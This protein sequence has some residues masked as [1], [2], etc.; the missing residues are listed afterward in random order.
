VEGVIV[1]TYTG[2]HEVVVI[3]PVERVSVLVTEAA[4]KMRDKGR[5]TGERAANVNALVVNVTVVGV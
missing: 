2:L 1:T 3:V 5:I 4:P